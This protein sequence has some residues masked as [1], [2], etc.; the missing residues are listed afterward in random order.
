M[1]GKQEEYLNWDE[2]FMGNAIVSAMGSK[3]PHNQVGA[4]NPERDIGKKEFQ[5]TAK[6]IQRILKEFRK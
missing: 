1:A 6:A 4:F 3:G 2:Y 5:E